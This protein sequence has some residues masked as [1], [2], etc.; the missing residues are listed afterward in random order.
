MKNM[1]LFSQAPADIVY[2]LSL[3][4]RFRYTHKIRIVVVNVENSYKF[5]QSLNLNAEL[6]FI[7]LVPQ[8]KLIRFLKFLFRLRSV[9]RQI[10]SNYKNAEIY[11]FSNCYDYVTAFFIEKLA[12]NNEIYFADLYNSKG[13]TISGVATKIKKLQVKLLLGISV[14]YFRHSTQR[15]YQYLA[16]KSV[17]FIAPNTLFTNDNNLDEFKYKVEGVEHKN[18]IL[19]LESNGSLDNRFT[20]YD[21]QISCVFKQIPNS[22]TMF[23]KPHPRLGY[24]SILDDYEPIIMEDYIPAEMIDLECFS[25]IIGI[26]SASVALMDHPNKLCIID[27]FEYKFSEINIEM[28]AYLDELPGEDFKYA[29][30]MD[31]LKDFLNYEHS[32]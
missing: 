21:Q 9:Y 29:K 24:S 14:K 10:F 8:K 6:D 11:Y 17:L 20:C 28:K 16:P 26:D 22:V 2:V 12:L 25:A 18:C 23:I 31:E 4:Q 5:F 15:A 19:F 1:I 30:N 27:L 13:P 7:P 3:Y 32:A